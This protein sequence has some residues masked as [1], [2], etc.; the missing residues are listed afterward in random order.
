MSEDTSASVPADGEVIEPVTRVV[1]EDSE[2]ISE[3]PDGDDVPYGI[4]NDPRK[5]V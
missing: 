3:E 2:A 5:I 1:V 4:G